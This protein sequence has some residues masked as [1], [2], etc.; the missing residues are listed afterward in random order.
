MTQ[1]LLWCTCPYFL[2]LHSSNLVLKMSSSESSTISPITFS[3]LSHGA[4]TNQLE[5]RI[6]DANSASPLITSD[7]PDLAGFHCPQPDLALMSRSSLPP[8]PGRRDDCLNRPFVRQTAIDHILQRVTKNS[9]DHSRWISTTRSHRWVLWEVA[10]R[11]ASDPKAAVHITVISTSRRTS[12]GETAPD[13]RLLPSYSLAALSPEAREHLAD[14]AE[15]LKAQWK[16]HDSYESLWYGRIFPD[17]IVTDLVC[18][19][20]VRQLYKSKLIML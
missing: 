7:D 17:R 19:A 16:S 20:I 6:W 9:A 4:R 12:I 15:L 13:W 10:R 5:F 11:L 1:H 8:V 18:T 2:K 14:E 3:I